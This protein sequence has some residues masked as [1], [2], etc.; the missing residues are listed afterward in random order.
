MIW[1]CTNDSLGPNAY[2]R[3]V[4]RGAAMSYDEVVEY[5]LGA[6]E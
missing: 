2:E 3:A 4:A 1:P 6:L 5:T